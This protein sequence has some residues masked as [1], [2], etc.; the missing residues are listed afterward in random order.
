[1]KTLIFPLMM[2]LSSCGAKTIFIQ[3]QTHTPHCGG[4]RPTPETAKGVTQAADQYRF[5]IYK[6]GETKEYK[7]M[8]MDADGM[9]NGRLKPGKYN[10][11]RED[12]TLTILEI[13]AKYKLSSSELFS[14]LGDDCLEKWRAEPDFKLEVVDGTIEYK[15]VLDIPCYTGMKPCLK[16]EG[17]LMQ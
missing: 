2:L 12:K 14:Y 3:I 8:T 11:F 1:M 13:K 10:I 15:F 17:P 6:D 7:K 16:Y 9:W 5:A 4:A